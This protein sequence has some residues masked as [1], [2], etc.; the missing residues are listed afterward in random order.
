LA[1]VLTGHAALA[2][3]PLNLSQPSQRVRFSASVIELPGKN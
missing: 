1:I 3:E 2:D